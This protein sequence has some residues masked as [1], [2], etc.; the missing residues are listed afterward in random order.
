MRARFVEFFAANISNPHTRRAYAR[1]IGE[2]LESCPPAESKRK[3]PVAGPAEARK[4]LDS[5]ETRTHA[6]LRDRALTGLM[7]CTPSPDR[8]GALDEGRGGLQRVATPYL[9]RTLK[10]WRPFSPGRTSNCTSVPS[11]KSSK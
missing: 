10:A 11:R 2:F 5:I 6:G 7:V 9:K 1:T 3:T 4:L 8:R